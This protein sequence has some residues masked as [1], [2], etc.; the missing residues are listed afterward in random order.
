[1]GGQNRRP[2]L[3]LSLKP[4]ALLCVA[5]ATAPL[6]QSQ[7]PTQEQSI[8]FPLVMA[9]TGTSQGPGDAPLPKTLST[10]HQQ[11]QRANGAFFGDYC[12]E[13]MPSAALGTRTCW[14]PGGK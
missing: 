7:D 6:R 14:S 3:Q 10:H 8:S 9:T 13:M 12:H 11:L 5:H 4:A 1:M 2:P